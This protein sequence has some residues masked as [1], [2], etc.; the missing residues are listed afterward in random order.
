MLKIQSS[1]NNFVSLSKTYDAG[2]TPIWSEV[3]KIFTGG[4]TLKTLPPVG[5]VIPAGTPVN[6][7]KIGGDITIL[8]AF[9]LSEALTAAAE[10]IKFT[11]VGNPFALVEGDILMVAPATYA[12]KG[13]AV[14][15][16][17]VTFDAET[18]IYTAVITAGAFS[19][20]TIAAG[21][22]FVEGTSAGA[23]VEMAV[24][25]NG[26]LWHDILISEG[27]YGGS[28]AVVIDGKIFIDRCS[29]SPD[30][31]NNALV[32]ITNEKEV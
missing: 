8:R 2:N 7:S 4:G 26:R 14:A 13:K 17:A 27:T 12:T 32:S 28:G 11:G 24:K 29:P 6:L 18:N 16:G 10:V 25:P 22:I 23:S 5:T 20:S 9:E 21:T 15:L 30:C 3:N 19:A 1:Y 31:V